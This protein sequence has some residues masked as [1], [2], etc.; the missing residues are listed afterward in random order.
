MQSVYIFALLLLTCRLA[1]TEVLK[2]SGTRA[3]LTAVGAQP[4]GGLTGKIVYAHGGHGITA[5]NKNDGHWSFQRGEGFEMIEDLG[6]YDQMSF[7]VDYLFGAGATVVPLRPVGHQTHEVVMDNDDPGVTFEGAWKTGKGPVYFGKAG[8][9][10]Y[11]E[12]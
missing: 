1:G 10:P 11:R 5:D 8:S 7:F 9:T 12:A 2:Q 6:N 4:R 3:G